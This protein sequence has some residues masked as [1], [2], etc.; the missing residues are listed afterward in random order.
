MI[1]RLLEK[2][3]KKLRLL[4]TMETGKKGKNLILKKLTMTPQLFVF[5]FS[6]NEYTCSHLQQH[7]QPL[8]EVVCF[9]L[10]YNK[11]QNGWKKAT[12]Q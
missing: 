1:K 6:S 9:F 2:T 4:P 12:R 11:S 8:M 3:A 7:L 10:N 5:Y